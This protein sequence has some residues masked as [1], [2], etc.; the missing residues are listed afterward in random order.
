MSFVTE[1]KEVSMD[2]LCSLVE[3]NQVIPI[4]GFE[5]FNAAFENQVGDLL[6][7]LMEAYDKDKCTELREKF[8][9]RSGFE[10]MNA[11]YH[12]LS[13]KKKVTFGITVSQ[14]ITRFR[15][16]TDPVPRCFEQ[17]ARIKN[18]RFYINATFFNSLEL[19]VSTF[20]VPKTVNEQNKSYDVV[21]YH[22][23]NLT[24]IEYD[25]TQEEFSII[26]F[27]KPTIYNLLGTHDVSAGEFVI[28]DVHFMELL[29]KMISNEKNKFSN[30]KAALKG[31]ALLFIGCDFPDWVLRFFLRFCVDAKMD[32][33][34][35]L[36]RNYIIEQLADD[37]SKAFLIG[38]YGI[39]KYRLKPDVFIGRLFKSL[40]LRN[41]NN[42][43]KSFYNNH[44][45]ISYNHEDKEIAQKINE[46]L[47]DNFVDTWFDENPGALES[48][49]EL[50]PKIRQAID[51]S[52]AILPIVTNH[53]NSEV[54]IKKYYKK[55]WNYSLQN[56]DLKTIFPV[57]ADNYNGHT[58]QGDVFTK[59]V[60]DFLLT[61]GNHFA[62]RQVVA[63]PGYLLSQ[64]FVD[65][66]KQL[67][68]NTRISGL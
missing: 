14:L 22:P 11:M 1:A 23:R 4:I 13:S 24:D 55:E 67:Q 15:K 46:Q 45:F 34:E 57:V 37:P 64:S 41:S 21:N 51:D 32:S 42:I 6:D 26:N 29:V 39:T 56:K 40:E 60:Q 48:G 68:Y 25:N 5:L 44:V 18:F 27:K 58:I 17:L 43:E 7:F 54:N 65:K 12:D 9:I 62:E 38:N 20:K 61:D 59:E 16:N 49:D 53:V 36:E 52:C 35:D 19:A 8:P 10:L 2:D 50:N 47:R 3:A 30:L 31:A 28:T 66:L 33:K 63:S